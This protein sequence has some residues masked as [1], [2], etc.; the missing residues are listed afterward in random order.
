[1]TRL[2]V[3]IDLLFSI[4]CPLASPVYVC[5][6]CTNVVWRDLVGLLHT[7]IECRRVPGPI[8][9][10]ARHICLLARGLERDEIIQSSIVSMLPK[11]AFSLTGL[12]SGAQRAEALP[13]AIGTDL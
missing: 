5:C 12:K 13:E 4:L 10:S 7:V 9:G 11:N 8:E 2:A 1:M 3:K 6:Q